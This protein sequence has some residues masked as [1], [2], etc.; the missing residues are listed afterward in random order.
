MQQLRTGSD[1][2]KKKFFIH[3]DYD[4]DGVTSAT[5]MKKTLNKLGVDD[6][7]ILVFI[8]QR[9]IDGYGLNIKT[10]Q[11]IIDEKFNI[12]VICQLLLFEVG[13]GKNS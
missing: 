4:A 11:K 7:N 12:V 9:E 5:I 2:G 3:G 13:Y 1:S 10:A 8:P 6:K